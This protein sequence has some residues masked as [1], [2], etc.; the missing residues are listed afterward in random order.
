MEMANQPAAEVATPAEVEP[1]NPT[2]QVTATEVE[3]GENDPPA[4]KTFSK[5]EVEAL[6]E[7]EIAKKTA[8]LLRQRDQERVRRELY[9]QQLQKIAPPQV[10]APGK[11][12]LSQ[13]ADPEQYAD[14]LANWKLEQK[15]LEDRAQKE[16]S[17]QSEFSS[18]RDEFL[19]ELE[20]TDGFDMKQFNRLPISVPMAEAILESD[21]GTK[22]AVHLTANPAEAE[23][24]A[25]LSPARQAAE[26]GKLEAKLSATPPKKPS[27]APAPINPVAGKGAG[28]ATDIYDQRLA[29][30]T[31]AWIEAR[32]KQLRGR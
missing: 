31:E 32:N 26:I 16:Q 19:A 3:P 23:R 29:S 30:N 7:K 25:N 17:K 8:K 22:I 15:S 18:K 13:F 4:E 24:I 6:V 27:N 14:A 28:P 9:E 5:S 10:Q 20:E 12:Q 2:P 11:P 1:Q 21:V